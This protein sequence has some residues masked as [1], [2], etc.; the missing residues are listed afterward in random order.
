ML[1]TRKT[2]SIGG[3][4]GDRRWPLVGARIAWK[5]A[6]G[7]VVR[8]AVLDGVP[9]E[10]Q[11]GRR[12]FARGDGMLLVAE[13]AYLLRPTSTASPRSPTFRLGRMS[14]LPPYAAKVALGAWHYTADFSDLSKIRPD[15]QPLQHHGS[16]GLY[17]LGDQ[18]L[19]TDSSRPTRRL[20]IFEQYGVGDGRVNQFASYAGAGIVMSGLI[21]T[22]ENDELGIAIAAANTTPDMKKPRLKDTAVMSP[23]AVPIANVARTAAQ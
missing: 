2:R 19:Y 9:V 23:T 7:V 8:A 16:S 11:E 13:A 3:F 22:R 5:P 6:K 4:H 10:R 17:V 14:G 1:T 18:T 20:T 12:L 15:G 21:G